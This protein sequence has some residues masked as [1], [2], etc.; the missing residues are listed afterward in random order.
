MQQ[1]IALAIDIGGTK[2][3]V[4]LV[5]EDGVI[6]HR[7]SH[8]MVV[9]GTASDALDCVH[10]AIE[11]VMKKGPEARPT[12]IGVSS[13][14]PLDPRKGIVL[15]SPN[16]PC[17]RNYPLL[18]EI[19]RAYGLPTRIDNDANSAGLAEAVWGAG[20]GYDNVFYATIGT[21]IGTAIVLNRNIFHGRTGAAAEGGHMSIDINA[22]VRCG[23]GKRGCIESMASGPALA[24][25]VREMI[26]KNGDR[27]G[28]LAGGD[29]RALNAE[30]VVGAWKAGDAL[31]TEAL[32]ATAD[33]LAAWF[34]NIID[35]LEPEVMIVGGG[36]GASITGW[37]EYIT[38]R[39]PA[40][41]INPRA[42]E[43][44]LVVAKYGGDA[45]IAG[46]ASLW[47]CESAK[48]VGTTLERA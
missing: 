2:V 47:F 27:G 9:S 16:M 1:R 40:W 15:N 35:L 48:A 45:G 43:I 25:R 12:M 28:L 46:S 17:W 26:A 4:G 10:G 23:C 3:A 19:Q 30:M 8:P 11:A 36:L 5:S 33:V 7:V 22:A 42:N 14:G 37:F 41:S 39:I 18:A 31:A 20:A 24:Q 13:P 34:G 21:G 6:L 32:T 38:A 29:L 44:P